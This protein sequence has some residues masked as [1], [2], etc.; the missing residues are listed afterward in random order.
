MMH[1]NRAT[2]LG[3]ISL[4]TMRFS[5]FYFA[6]GRAVVRGLRP[7]EWVRDNVTERTYRSETKPDEWPGLMQ[8]TD[9]C[10]II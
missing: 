2:R 3:R 5:I 1:A 9:S 8:R 10:V 7:C 6:L 4:L